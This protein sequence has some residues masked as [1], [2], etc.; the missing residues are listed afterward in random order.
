M[1]QR[2]VDIEVVTHVTG[3]VNHCESCQVFIDGVGIGDRIHTE[4]MQSYPEEFIRDWQRISDWVFELAEAYPGKLVI[5]ITDAQS[6]QG[7]W[8]SIS[9]GVHQ[10][11][12]FIIDGQ[13]KYHG[14][15]S[16]QLN[17]LI[18]RHVSEARS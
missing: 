9:K 16:Q 18:D 15:D 10:Y 6:M 2:L 11:P 17:A 7:L 1:S 14:W 4:D 5:R 13:E 12:T 8:K 3:S